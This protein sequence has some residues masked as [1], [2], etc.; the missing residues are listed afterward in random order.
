MFALVKFISDNVFYV[1]KSDDIQLS[2]RIKCR[3]KW[4]DGYYYSAV[5]ICKHD[6]EE[7]LQ[8]IQ[9]NLEQNFPIVVLKRHE[10]SE[11]N[12]CVEVSESKNVYACIEQNTSTH[13][14][15]EQSPTINNFHDNLAK[16]ILNCNI[17]VLSIS[18]T[19]HT[20]AN[21]QINVDTASPGIEVDAASNTVLVQ[22]VAT[23][24]FVNVV[25]N[26][27][28][29]QVMDFFGSQLESPGLRNSLNV[30]N[31]DIASLANPSQIECTEI[32]HLS[33]ESIVPVCSMTENDCQFI[34]ELDNKVPLLSESSKKRKNAYTPFAYNRDVVIT[35]S[36]TDHVRSDVNKKTVSGC[37]E[38][39]RRRHF[40][41]Y[42]KKLYAKLSQHLE[43]S[44][45]DEMAVRMF[46]SLPTT[47][48]I[49]R[50]RWTPALKRILNIVFADH[51]DAGTLPSLPECLQA[52]E[53]YKELQGFTAAALK[54][55]VANKQRRRLREIS[56]PCHQR[57]L[58]PN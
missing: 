40:C 46:L 22:D 38:K 58:F 28:D 57:I 17:N 34:D 44:H 21:D 16:D 9:N 15:F 51:F 11:H 1:C 37:E 53:N 29:L 30:T 24:E 47:R 13:H 45:R 4:I 32:L 20:F 5:T 8:D 54:T 3:V 52:M 25:L 19:A 14:Q 10:L 35:P 36:Y 18:P 31:C 12:F 55:A 50:T 56:K 42:C 23:T 48:N 26:D 41:I 49:R 39:G 27:P 6:C 43:W 2:K 33:P 7:V